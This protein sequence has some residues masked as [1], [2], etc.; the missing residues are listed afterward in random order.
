[1]KRL[2]GMYLVVPGISTTAFDGTTTTPEG[3]VSEGNTDGKTVIEDTTGITVPRRGSME[4]K[5][6]S[7]EEILTQ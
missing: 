5:E 2:V 4:K 1:M 3:S 6:K 7:R